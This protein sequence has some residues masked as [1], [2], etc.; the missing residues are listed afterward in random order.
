[1]PHVTILALNPIFDQG[2][3]MTQTQSDPAHERLVLVKHGE[4][5]EIFG[6]RL[7]L[8]ADTLVHTPLY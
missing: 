6:W 7:Q 1:M 3:Q 2:V 4:C 8:T 5:G